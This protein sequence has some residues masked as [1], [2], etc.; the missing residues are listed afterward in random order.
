MNKKQYAIK[1]ADSIITLIEDD[2][3]AST[4]TTLEPLIVAC[5]SLAIEGSFQCETNDIKFLTNHDSSKTVGHVKEAPDGSFLFT[6]NSHSDTARLNW[7][8]AHPL[9]SEVK[10]GHDDG[11]TAKVWAISCN[12]AHSL[13]QVIDFMILQSESTPERKG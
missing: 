8:E 5:I 3:G 2:D 12:K 9:K 11:K 6:P 4:L 7:L 13:R 1:A 10:G